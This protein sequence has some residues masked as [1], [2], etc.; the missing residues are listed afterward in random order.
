MYLPS[1]LSAFRA[2]F[3]GSFEPAQ[4]HPC[5]RIEPTAI[6]QACCGLPYRSFP[7]T[8]A[9]ALDSH[10]WLGLM[11]PGSSSMFA[12]CLFA[13]GL[14][15]RLKLQA[16]SQPVFEGCVALATP[17]AHDSHGPQAVRRKAQQLYGALTPM[18]NVNIVVCSPGPPRGPK[19]VLYEGFPAQFCLG[20]SRSRGR[21]RLHACSLC[22]AG[23]PGSQSWRAARCRCGHHFA[24]TSGAPRGV[25][26]KPEPGLETSLQRQSFCFLSCTSRI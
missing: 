16:C 3:V 26:A 15:V 2:E 24:R 6:H 18:E 17:T 19:G 8:R 20:P 23:R 10:L 4:S 13:P 11:F 22:L 7:R 9:G 5:C 21:W 14:F 12:P 1:T 25:S